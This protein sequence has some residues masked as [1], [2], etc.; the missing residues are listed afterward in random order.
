MAGYK[1]KRGSTRSYKSKRSRKAAPRRRSRKTSHAPRRRRSTGHRSSGRK[2]GRSTASRSYGG[3]F[4]GSAH[5][6]TKTLKVAFGDVETVVLLS[7]GHYKFLSR[8]AYRYVRAHAGTENMTSRS[9]KVHA[10]SIMVDWY[11]SGVYAAYKRGIYS[12]DLN[13]INALASHVTTT[14]GGNAYRSGGHSKSSASGN[15]S[16]EHAGENAA[17]DIATGNDVGAVEAVADNPVFDADAVHLA[18]RLF[19]F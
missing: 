19:H 16:M 5:R 3:T 17:A 9:I 6:G 11:K 1:R 14:H 15:A 12:A 2:Y 7:H 18:G 4:I 8:W 13:K 10:E